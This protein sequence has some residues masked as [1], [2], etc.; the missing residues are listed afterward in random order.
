LD[1]TISL[2]DGGMI[3]RPDQL[4]II[5]FLRGFRSLGPWWLF[6]LD[7]S[8]YAPEEKLGIFAFKLSRPE[9]GCE[10]VEHRRFVLIH[11]THLVEKFLESVN[12]PDEIASASSV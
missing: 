12:A 5:F 2:A 3:F 7:E 9:Y 1:R 10:H 8:N 4:G 11:L 6:P